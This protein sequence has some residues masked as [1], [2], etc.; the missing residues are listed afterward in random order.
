M[1]FDAKYLIVALSSA[2]FTLATIWFGSFLTL[3]NEKK[4]A[5]AMQ[6]L[7][8]QSV[9]TEMLDIIAM[10]SDIQERAK[11]ALESSFNNKS[12]EWLYAPPLETLAYSELFKIVHISFE[13]TKRRNI[14]NFY[15]MVSEINGIT[16]K[17]R[18]HLQSMNRER[19]AYLDYNALRIWCNNLTTLHKHLDSPWNPNDQDF[20]AEQKHINE[21]FT[22]IMEMHFGSANE[23]ESI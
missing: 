5:A 14:R 2:G 7:Q 11:L 21:Q 18:N 19:R 13:K 23:S 16:E 9:E 12:V 4:K 6:K 8:V 17:C 20:L 10:I 22:R 3:H 1:V 15:S